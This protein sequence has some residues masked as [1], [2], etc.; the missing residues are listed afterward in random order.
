MVSPSRRRW[1]L[2]SNADHQPTNSRSSPR[3]D[4]HIAGS[5]SAGPMPGI[6]QEMRRARTCVGLIAIT[7]L[8]CTSKSG[9]NNCASKCLQTCPKMLGS[10]MAAPNNS[11]RASLPPVDAS[12]DCAFAKEALRRLSR[13]LSLLPSAG[14][15][16]EVRPNRGGAGLEALDLLAPPSNL[17]DPGARAADPRDRSM[18]GAPEPEN[19][20]GPVE[21]TA[22]FSWPGVWQARATAERSGLGSVSLA[23]RHMSA[24]IVASRKVR[25]FDAAAAMSVLPNGLALSFGA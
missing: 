7:S 15:A 19:A 24:S 13:A 23:A 20:I 4:L 1:N 12:P 18:A 14:R 22:R 10:V 25:G 5:R 9:P 2:A 6:A 8:Q 17:T 3:A 16:G 21:A 11:K